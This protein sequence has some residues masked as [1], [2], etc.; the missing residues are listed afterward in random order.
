[1]T[2]GAAAAALKI[3]LRDF[4]GGGVGDP[5]GEILKSSG[6]G[7]KGIIGERFNS[8]GPILDNED[9]GDEVF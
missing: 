6:S 8:G 7:D 1:M 2:V 3:S 9:I 4:D 5:I